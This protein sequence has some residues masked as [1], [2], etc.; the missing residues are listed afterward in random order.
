MNKGEL[1]YLKMSDGDRIFLN[2]NEIIAVFVSHTTKD[3]S[4]NDSISTEISETK[5]DFCMSNK[6]RY[7]YGFEDNDPDGMTVMRQL[8]NFVSE[9]AFR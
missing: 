3:N 8:K 2:A 9:E 5:L 6:S 7:S 1:I 4:N